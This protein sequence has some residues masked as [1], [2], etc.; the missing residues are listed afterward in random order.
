MIQQATSTNPLFA[1]GTPPRFEEITPAHAKE[2]VPELLE[3]ASAEFSAFEEDVEPTWDGI[4]GRLRAI[5]EP[6]EYAWHVTGHLMGVRN[7]EELR[8][9]H[10]ALQPQVVEFFT[11]MGQSAATYAA[12]E[13]LVAGEAWAE[14]DATRKRLVEKELLGM[15]LSGISLEGEAKERF[16]E[17]QKELAELST[18]FSNAV[19][20]SRK[21][22]ELVITDAADAEGL[23]ETLRQTAAASAKGAGHEDATADA[24]PWRITLDGPSAGP[25]LMHSRNRDQREAV[26]RA[27]VTV[28]SEGEY[29][30]KPRIE[31]ILTLRKEK[32]GLLGYNTHAEISLA[33]KMADDVAAVDQ[34]TAELRDAA[35]PKAEQDHAELVEFARSETGD[36]T[37]ELANWDVGFWSERMRETKYELS[38]EELRP[39]YPF[40]KVLEGLFAVTKRLFDVDVIAADGEVQVWQSDVRYFRIQDASGNDIASF[41]LDPYSRPED[42]RGG[43]WMDNLIG[44]APMA[45]GG[46]RLPTAVLVCNQTPPVGDA[47]SLMTFGEVRTLFHEFGH[48]LQHML[49]T[50]DVPEAAGIESVEWDAVELPSQFM[51][52][53]T[54]HED[55]VMS[56]AGH[57]E[58][59]EPM[60]KELFERLVAAK[61]YRS[62]SGVLRQL[63]FGHLDMELHHHYDPAGD[64]T[65][66]EVKD[67]VV[68]I[69]T[70]VPPL[71]EDHFE[72][73]FSHI[74]AGGYSAGY[75]SYKWAEVLS[76]DAFSAFEEAGL[77]DDTAIVEMGHKF[78]DTVLAQ[79]GSRHPM[80]V[81]TEFRGRGP[82]TDALKR[83]TDLV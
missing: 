79:G 11:R 40:P 54:Y 63:Y 73:S 27:L 69:S 14:L 9:V 74:F 80:D 47:P 71:P 16:N 68:A 12:L 81:F 23:P 26:Y 56:F 72:C 49:T 61:N 29:D 25:F 32:A 6:L 35:M 75:Y 57:F 52:N 4:F 20:D 1:H 34:L 18:G 58:T 31:R 45:D 38:D 78:R 70:V 13:G 50:V 48:G 5:V 10:E 65:V 64:E 7:S 21:A 67:R 43:A 30:N 51:E 17:I 37:L 24:G 19:L 77:D 28:A 15:K 42:K 46:L 33:T 3:R 66:A 8:E 82:S 53:W 39:Y 62:A 76:A 2:A 59:S 36:A 22:Y 60:P 55:T 83:H 44:R 41:Y